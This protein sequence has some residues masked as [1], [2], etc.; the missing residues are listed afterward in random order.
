MDGG[1][2]TR[3]REGI[4]FFIYNIYRDGRSHRLQPT[5]FEIGGG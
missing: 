4:D 3:L 1:Q 2:Q 5:S